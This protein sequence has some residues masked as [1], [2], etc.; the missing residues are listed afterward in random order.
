MRLRVLSLVLLLLSLTVIAK[1]FYIQI[2][3]NEKYLVEAES[4]HVAKYKIQADRGEIL[5]S[6]GFPIVSNKKA[7]L[8]YISLKEFREKARDKL[9]L[10]NDSA[11]KLSQLFWEYDKSIKISNFAPVAIATGSAQ[12]DKD[13][14]K[15]EA[16]KKSE[17][18]L[19]AKISDQDLVWVPLKR[20]VNENFKV[21]VE[22]LNIPGIGFQEISTRSYPEAT[23][24]AQTI[25][26]V[27]L[28]SADDSRGYVGLEG[29]Y[30][31]ELK[32]REGFLTHEV[33]AAGRPIL[34]GKTEDT[35]VVQGANLQTSI[36]RT[37]QFIVEKKLE[38][39]VKKYGAAGGTVVL[40][41]PSTGA[42]IASASRP[43]FFPE[44]WDQ[45]QKD[46]LVDP[47][48]GVTYEPGST[49]KLITYSAALDEGVIT[50]Q[51]TCVCS[52]PI[53]LNGSTVRTWNNKYHPN[54]TMAEGLQNSD[55]IVTSFIAS[56]LGN[57]TL[58]KYI[59]R[60]GFGELTNVDL[61]GEEKGIINDPKG[62]QEIDLAAA[63]FGQGLTVT[64]IQMTRAV[65]AIA[66]G[67]QLMQ[68]MVVQKVI[69]QFGDQKTERG[70]KS[71]AVRQ[72]L[73]PTTAR[74]MTEMMINNVENG[75]SKFY[76]PKGMK[77]AGKTG[78]AQIP[79][80]GRYDASKYTA[81][82]IGFAPVDKPKFVMLVKYDR[83]TASIY[84]STTAAPT[85]F[86]I[87]KEL[88]TYWGIPLDQ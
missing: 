18:E 61:Q 21:K 70:L 37:A 71:V 68:P 44:Y 58:F 29:Y 32:G 86:E 14:Q 23:L 15:K 33:D 87:A 54:S 26:F 3:Q 8:V 11:T 80:E 5:S 31:G 42:V 6:D 28:D 7:Y 67:G 27:G 45:Y 53:T 46:D 56:K 49:F 16:L 1:L 10:V 76:L 64:P 43:N 85:F 41:D 60:Y 52:G 55:N 63:S 19:I 25:G 78:T 50:P 35:P 38:E 17:E 72:V 2:I 48:I 62:W 84:G 4:Q 57:E 59:K 77:V 39:G 12:S 9:D 75:E 83:P 81:S 24:S 74:Q 51:T 65:A 34:V 20:K 66:N 22:A 73:K 30:D 82:F 13:S 79:V 40:M 88:Y 69:R 47:A 36:D